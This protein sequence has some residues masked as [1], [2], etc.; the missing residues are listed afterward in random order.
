MDIE[1]KYQVNHYLV[2]ALLNYVDNKEIAIPEIQRP[3]VWDGAK[4][5]DL[6][7]A[8]IKAIQSDIS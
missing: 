1:Q 8:F 3:F 4:V 5:R 6:I 7:V 2:S